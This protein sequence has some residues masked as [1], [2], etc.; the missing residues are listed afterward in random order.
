M[1]TDVLCVYIR[2]LVDSLPLVWFSH[3]ASR[4]RR[5]KSDYTPICGDWRRIRNPSVFQI[6]IRVQVIL[7]LVRAV[8][9]SAIRLG[10]IAFAPIGLD[11]NPVVDVFILFVVVV[12]DVAEAILPS[13]RG[14]LYRSD[15][16]VA[17][18]TPVIVV[19]LTANV[20]VFRLQSHQ[21]LQRVTLP[22]RFRLQSP[23]VLCDEVLPHRVI[24]LEET[25]T[26][27][28]AFDDHVTAPL[29]DEK[30]L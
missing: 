20:H 15:E 30:V 25:A 2:A 10:D 5:G 19:G 11:A 23:C 18:P 16:S 21:P 28:V 4:R 13:I 26:F 7:N 27:V 3:L 24:T 29:V 1:I 22:R 12:A 6:E 8:P 17:E 9:F 14:L